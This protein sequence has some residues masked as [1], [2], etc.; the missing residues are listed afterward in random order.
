MKNFIICSF[1]LFFFVFESTFSQDTTR[2][3][4]K[5]IPAPKKIETKKPEQEKVSPEKSLPPIDMKEYIIKGKEEIKLEPAEKNIEVKPEV[6]QSEKSEIK[7]I[8]ED[9]PKRPFEQSGIK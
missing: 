6:K 8:P 2:T 7:D 3:E 9:L 5:I 4:K 1:V